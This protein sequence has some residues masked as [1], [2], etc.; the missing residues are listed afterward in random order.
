M[1]EELIGDTDA[2]LIYYGTA[3]DLWVL[4]T[5]KNVLK[6]LSSK[7]KGRDY[8]RA[9]YLATPKDD[10]KTGNYLS[11]ADR[12]YPAIAQSELSFARNRKSELAPGAVAV[13]QEAFAIVNTGDLKLFDEL[14]LLGNEQA[15]AA[16]LNALIE[17]N[18]SLRSIIQVVPAFE[19]AA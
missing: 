17:T 19:L 2:V 16:R 10:I 7:Q 3:T 11:I 15:A 18:P 12:T 5:R 9:L 1:E 6:V 14:S 4:R 8:A 13:A